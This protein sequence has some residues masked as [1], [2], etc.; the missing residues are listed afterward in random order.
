M[1]SD[2]SSLPEQVSRLHALS[3]FSASNAIVH[4]VGDPL[5]PLS[6]KFEKCGLVSN[7]VLLY[8][9]DKD[10]YIVLENILNNI[11]TR[12]SRSTSKLLIT[13]VNLYCATPDLLSWND[14]VKDDCFIEVLSHFFPERVIH[15]E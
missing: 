6:L 14:L 1:F 12:V 7:L 11:Q 8:F 15:S 2:L 4:C 13:P 3:D 10:V 9:K 5:L